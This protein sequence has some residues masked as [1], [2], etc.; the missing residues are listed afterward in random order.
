M[1]VGVNDFQEV[2]FFENR[3]NGQS[4]GFCVITLGSES[5]MRVVMD[6]LPKKELNGQNPVV[7]LPTKQALNQ[8]ESQQKTRPTPPAP[9]NSQ[10]PGMN[11]GMGQMGM[12]SMP[13]QGMHPQRMMN[14]N[15]MM[16]GPNPMMQNPMNNPMQRHPGNGGPPM[17]HPNGPMNHPNGPPRFQNNWNG[18]PRGQLGMAPGPNR[19][20]M[21]M[22]NQGPMNQ[23][24]PMGMMNM[25][26]RGPRPDWGNRP[27]MHPGG[28]QGQQGMPPR[29]PQGMPL[30]NQGAPAPHVNPA[31]FNNNMGQGP[32]QQPMGAAPPHFNQQGPRPMWPVGGPNKMPGQ[33]FDAPPVSSQPPIS[34]VEFEEIMG[35]NRT[36]S[37]SA[38]ARAVS[39]AAAGEYASAIETLA[40]AISLIKQSKVANDERCKIL[41]TSL[42]D[43]LQGIEAK[44]YNRRDRSERSRSRERRRRRERSNSRTYRR[45]RSREHR[46]HRDRGRDE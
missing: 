30:N 38:I 31:F 9:P 36:V 15:P 39:D 22:M 35:R 25:P 11:M 32:M 27:P 17:N 18:P 3:A 29:P 13:P 23:G 21:Q 7:T 8:F 34:E 41:I 33:G 19:P 2:K 14:P 10:K 1:G 20:P 4:K 26:P 28:F 16:R 44:S 24:R 5:S 40:T 12:Q 37:S 6:N 46:E 42:Q 45:S 43:T